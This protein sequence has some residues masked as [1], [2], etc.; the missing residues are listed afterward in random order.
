MLEHCSTAGPA[1]PTLLPLTGT[2]TSNALKLGWTRPWRELVVTVSGSPVCRL[3][4][5]L[6][7]AEAPTWAF[8]E[9]DW[10]PGWEGLGLEMALLLRLAHQATAGSRPISL[11]AAL[12]PPRLRELIRLLPLALAGRSPE[13]RPQVA[14]ALLELGRA[15]P[16]G[17]GARLAAAAATRL[18]RL[19][20]D[21]ALERW[22]PWAAALLGLG[23]E[24]DGHDE[25]RA[26]P[27]TPDMGVTLH[28]RLSAPPGWRPQP[29]DG[30]VSPGTWELL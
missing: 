18:G 2:L 3:R 13:M 10:T 14:S 30:L 15:F 27:S 4:G 24:L 19:S 6:L 11:R 1:R 16:G 29:L 9:P 5:E 22:S 25:D 12:R 23:F 21:G 17:P 7:E 20:R 26:R 28:F 8:G